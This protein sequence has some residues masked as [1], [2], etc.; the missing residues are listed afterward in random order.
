MIGEEGN[1]HTPCLGIRPEGLYVPKEELAVTLIKVVNSVTLVT[2]TTLTTLIIL[3]N[4]GLRAYA[5][6]RKEELI[7]DSV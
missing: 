6:G 2:P 1:F 7:K 3:I 4:L 5:R